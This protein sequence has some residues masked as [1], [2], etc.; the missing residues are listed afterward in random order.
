MSHQTA[1]VTGASR[2][3]GR[4]IATAL[5]AAGT[6]V[7]GIARDKQEL[8]AV[9]DEL[10]DAFIPVAADATDETLARNV[11]REHRPTLLVLNAGVVPHM[12]P[13]HEQTW[14]TF[15]RNWHVDTRHVFTWTG[16]ALREP[17][18]PDSVV[19]AMS[20]GAALAGSP[21]SGGYASAKAAIRYIRGYAADESKR[22]G[23]DIRFVALLPQL[24]PTTGLGTIGVAGYAARQGVEPATF[25][26]NLQP[27]LT[28]D[29]VAKAVLDLAAD[30]DSAPEYQVDGAGLRALVP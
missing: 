20:S 13:V 3:F 17:L 7:V 6:N 4:A 18:A 19:L 15:S 10:G 22:A 29:Q 14:E 12:A 25:V 24:T 8:L 28:P 27:I 9:R 16:A 5:V 11:I 30:S 2:G 23:L 26:Q 21:L 1:V